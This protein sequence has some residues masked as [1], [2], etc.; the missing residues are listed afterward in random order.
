MPRPRRSASRASPT[1]SGS[2]AFSPTTGELVAA[3]TD[4]EPEGENEEYACWVEVD[5]E[6]QRLGRMYWAGDLWA[7]AGTADGLDALP[8]GALFGVSLSSADGGLGEPVLTGSL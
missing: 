6:R 5:G 1:P 3:A 7:W 8:A 2:L 4:L